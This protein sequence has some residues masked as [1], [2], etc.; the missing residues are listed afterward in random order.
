MKIW[1]F[2]A[3][4]GL[5]TFLAG[6]VHARNVALILPI[7]A[8]LEAA[9]V[10]DRPSGAVR[11]FFGDQA[12]PAIATKIETYVATPRTNAMAKSD[13]RACHEALL[14]TLLAL[15]KRA[16]Q[17][18]A[19]AAREYRQFLPKAGDVQPYRIRMPRRQRDCLGGAEGRSGEAH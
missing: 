10:P 1:G 5:A 8:A 18:G 11:F 3:V 13:Q 16:Q 19:N 12:T 9:D 2:S 17:K 4:F 7:A 6:G 14:W 15:E